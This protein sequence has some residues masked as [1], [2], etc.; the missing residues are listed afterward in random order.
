M[1]KACHTHQIL[2]RSLYHEFYHKFVRSGSPDIPRLSFMRLVHKCSAQRHAKGFS[3]WDQYV[4]MLFCQLAQCKSLRE[5]SDG[6][7]I[8]C[9]KLSHLGLH[10]APARSTLSYANPP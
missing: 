5:I 2:Q 10:T 7:A 1:V 9:G 6:L 4:S 8:T 3:S